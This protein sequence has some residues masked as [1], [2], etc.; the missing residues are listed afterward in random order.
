MLALPFLIAGCSGSSDSGTTTTSS[1]PPPS[2]VASSTT[3]PTPPPPDPIPVP[4]AEEIINGYS[5]TYIVTFDSRYPVTE[6]KVTNGQAYATVGSIELSGAVNSAG[7]LELTGRA[8]NGVGR[9]TMRG[10]IAG[11][12]GSYSV[13]DGTYEYLDPVLPSGGFSLTW[14]AE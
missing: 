12:P 3:N 2:P 1:T 10:T 4:T 7:V 6:L 11:A 8:N 5:K 9:A 14:T 13:L